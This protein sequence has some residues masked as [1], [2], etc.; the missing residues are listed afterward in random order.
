[1]LIGSANDVPAA[2]QIPLLIEEREHKIFLKGHFM[3]QTDHHKAFEQNANVLLHIYRSPL[4]M[5]VRVGILIPGIRIHLEL[6][7]HSRQR[8]KCIF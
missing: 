6:Y 4:A 2:T 1:M 7:K 8:A 3:R 5:S